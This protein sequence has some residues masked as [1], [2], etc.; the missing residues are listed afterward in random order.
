[1]NGVANTM[2]QLEQHLIKRGTPAMMFRFSPSPDVR[3]QTEF[4]AFELGRGRLRIPID[5]DYDFDLLFLRHL[6]RIREMLEEFRPTVIHVTGPGDCGI[7]GTLLAWKLGVP[8]VAS[9]HTNIHEFA[10][11]R[12]AA[13][14]D[15]LLPGGELS[16]I[17]AAIERTVLS[18]AC[19]Y[20]RAARHILAPNVELAELLGRRTG[21]PVSAMPRGV[22]CE[23]FDPCRRSRTDGNLVFGYV[24]RLTPE[25]NVRLLA[26]IGRSLRAAGHEF[27][28]TVTGEGPERDF[29]AQHVPGVRFT[30][31]LRGAALAEAYAN[32]DL[33]LFP[34]HTDTYGNVALEAL[35]SGVPVL[36]TSTGGP[37]YLIED[38]VTGWVA[39]SDE[40][41][42]EL[43]V[44]AAR[45]PARLQAMRPAAR[46]AALK[47]G[48]DEAFTNVLDAYQAVS[49]ERQPR[50]MAMT[51][52]W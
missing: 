13:V 18:L 41:F 20:Y 25:K 12:A 1:V 23:R 17:A 7:L 29:L 36:A 26:D 49:Q 47:R 3:R 19:R 31:V 15:R 14:A 51:P 4:T 38:G 40:H 44:D 45:Q 42:A 43:A 30:G 46:Q 33:L 32:L 10:A 39:S 8:L 35:A 52:A 50:A 5:S 11:R 16:W 6:A 2:R 27:D 37:K 9:W 34:S 24:G 48:W 21:R 28:I 22:D